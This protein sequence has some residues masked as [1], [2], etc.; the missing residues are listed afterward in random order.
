METC[1]SAPHMRAMPLLSSPSGMSYATRHRPSEQV[2]LEDELGYLQIR[3]APG[4]HREKVS[5][6]VHSGSQLK[7]NHRHRFPL[8]QEESRHRVFSVRLDSPGP[9]PHHVQYSSICGYW[10]AG[11]ARY[12][13][14]FVTR[15][16]QETAG[17]SSVRIAN[18][19]KLHGIGKAG[20]PGMAGE[21]CR[22][23]LSPTSVWAHSGGNGR[24]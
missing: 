9:N 2:H 3:R 19:R 21:S 23:T 15:P 7:A 4:C 5:L 20:R 16:W 6:L 10:K 13:S 12:E 11:N 22:P 8:T 17:K 14:S 18:I 1:R 24:T